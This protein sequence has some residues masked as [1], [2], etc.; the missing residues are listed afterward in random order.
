MKVENF[1]NSPISRQRRR[2]MAYS[3]V[4]NFTSRARFSAILSIDDSG[5]ETRPVG[6]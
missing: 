2:W 3:S 6:R 5:H 4:I 1:E